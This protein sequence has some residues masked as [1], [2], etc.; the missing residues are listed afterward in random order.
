[1]QC[2]IGNVRRRPPR[3]CISLYF[4]ENH[5]EDSAAGHSLPPRLCRKLRDANG[6]SARAASA[7]SRRN[8]ADNR[9]E[10]DENR[11]KPQPCFAKHPARAIVMPLMLR[12]R[13]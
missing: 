13:A 2:G 3:R 4:F 6:K 7:T 12:S 11:E 5:G 8:I 10:Q 9:T 1:M